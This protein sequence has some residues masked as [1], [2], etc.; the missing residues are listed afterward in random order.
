L[1]QDALDTFTAIHARFEAGRTHLDLAAL[2][3]TQGNQDGATAHLTQAQAL[4]TALQ[5]PRYVERTAYLARA[6][7]I[8]LRASS[9]EAPTEGQP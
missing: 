7:G 2:A 4:F 1:L 3:H 6:Y 9:P 8:T 5:V